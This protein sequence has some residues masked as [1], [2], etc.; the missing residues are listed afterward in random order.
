M[1]SRFVSDFAAKR[2]QSIPK[3]T[4]W[5]EFTPL[6][7]K[8]KA[9]NLGQGFPNFDVP[10]EIMKH[11]NAAINDP[12]PLS[13]QYSRMLG[14]PKLVDQIAKRYTKTL[15]R[16]IDG[17]S[18]VCVCNGTTQ[19]LNLCTSAFVNP[20]EQVL[21]IE[22][23]FDLYDNDIMI[24]HGKSKFV[25]L[26]P[27]GNT[28]NEWTLD[29]DAL[30][31]TISS[32]DKKIKALML[33]TPQNVPGKVWT[34]QELEKLSE[35]VI[36]HDMMVFA[37]EVYDKFVFDGHEHISIASLP[38]MWDRT[39][40]MCSAGKM[41]TVTGWKIGWVVAP[42]HLIT[43]LAQ[44]FAHQSFSVATPLCAA[45]AG[46][47]EEASQPE[48]QFFEKVVAGYKHRRDLLIGILEDCGLKAVVPQ[49]S[50]FVMADISKIP[51]GVFEEVGSVPDIEGAPTDVQKDWKF[52][53][54][55][56]KEV[57]VGCVPCTAFA[58]KESAPFFSNFVRFAFCKKEEDIVEAGKR[59][60]DKL[61]PHVK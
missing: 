44:V 60:R 47:L 9:V 49:G 32:S 2:L 6:C 61:K 18:E 52:A 4:V 39:V 35:I 59:L 13:Q 24:A 28:A 11:A 16:N 23:F 26:R 12:D 51:S 17:L 54:W 57:G 43:P 38:G 31:K 58:S 1:T 14:H 19:A 20:D 27:A 21:V 42:K 5:S 10:Q 25:P 33:N 40:T 50:Y 56:V 34:R 46:A 3:M 55:L 41:F 36:K 8:Y 7:A 45:V 48:S 29:F 15:G 30:D 53:R 37:D 22:P